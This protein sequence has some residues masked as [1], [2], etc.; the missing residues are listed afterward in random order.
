M[1]SSLFRK[2]YEVVGDYKTEWW[3]ALGKEMT[4]YFGKNCYWIFWRY[5]GIKITRAW[6]ITQKLNDRN[7]NHFMQRIIKG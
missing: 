4:D 1:D 7:F 3:Q 2:K 5:S 6:H